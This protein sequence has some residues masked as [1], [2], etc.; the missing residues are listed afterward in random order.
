MISD[1]QKLES[2]IA[3]YMPVVRSSVIEIFAR[4]ISERHEPGVEAVLAY[5]S[6]LRDGDPA[7][8]LID[9]YVLTRDM[10][11]ISSNP[12]SRL[13]CKIVP[14]NVYYAEA[15]ID[16]TAYRAK[17]AI[18]PLSLFEARVSRQT[19][20][21]YFWARFAQ[22]CAI[23]LA[24][25]E[26][27]RARM[28]RALAQ[29]VQTTAGKFAALAEPQDIAS[30]LWV[31]GLQMTYGSELRSEGADRARQIVDSN[32]AYFDVVT[33]A[34]LGKDW[35]SRGSTG[36]GDWRRVQL[37]GKGLSVLRLFKAAFTF[38]GGADYIAWKIA[39]HSGQPV[40]LTDWQRRHPIIAAVVLL[41]RLLKSG[42]VR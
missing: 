19:S 12:L 9:Y 41:P 3:A 27:A 11:T 37:V 31:R 40:T 33:A 32:V 23:V 4:I 26:D 6:C 30:G 35:A 24:A 1:L 18:L 2:A 8:G 39:R 28:M 13:A 29:A 5:G 20:N 10:S 25:D 17:Y 22:P 38:R 42:A 34:A 16:G 7:D 36:I 14:P 15:Q 21:P